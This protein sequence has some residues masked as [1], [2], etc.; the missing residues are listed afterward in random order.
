M[1]VILVRHPK[2]VCEKGLCYG[3]L[4][5][6]CDGDALNS[7]VE[8]IAKLARTCRIVTSPARRALSLAVR[9]APD[10]AIEPRL[11][12]L[13][14]GDWDGHRWQ[15]LGREAI[16]AWQRGLPASAPPNG[17]TLNGMAARCVDWLSCLAPGG[18][19]VLAITHAGPIRVIRALLERR[20]LLTYFSASVPFAE[21]L[22]LDAGRCSA[23]FE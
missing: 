4:D 3:R 21:P 18:V 1:R 22:D 14:F 12:E 2:P 9:L 5:L 8:R 7:A 16:E 20:P 19:P 6:E 11:Q 10:P 17:E 15:D 13:D 23:I